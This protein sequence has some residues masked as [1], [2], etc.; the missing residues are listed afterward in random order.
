LWQTEAR[1]SSS[2]GFNAE[3]VQKPLFPH[4]TWTQSLQLYDSR[5]STVTSCIWKAGKVVSQ[6]ELFCGFPILSAK[7]NEIT[8]LEQGMLPRTDTH[9]RPDQQSHENR[10]YDDAETR[11]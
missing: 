7:F 8:K 4:S 10:D 5:D 3:D 1:A 9:L 11:K 6:P 2:T